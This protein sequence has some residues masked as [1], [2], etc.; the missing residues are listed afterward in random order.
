MKEDVCLR[1]NNIACPPNIC[2]NNQ[3]L[4]GSF[5]ND[6]LPGPLLLILNNVDVINWWELK[7]LT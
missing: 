3:F 2:N 1:V 6:T 7:E 4:F 5:K